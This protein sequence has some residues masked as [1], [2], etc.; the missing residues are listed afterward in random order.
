MLLLKLFVVP[1]GQQ[2]IND[3]LTGKEWG[4]VML[5]NQQTAVK[6]SWA[7]LVSS[8]QFWGIFLFFIL[9]ILSS[10]IFHTFYSGVWWKNGVSN[11]E[12]DVFRYAYIAG[13]SMS[14]IPAWI[15]SR[16]N[17]IYPLYLFCGLF[18]LALLLFYLDMNGFSTQRGSPN[19]SI[20]S[21]V[22]RFLIEFSSGAVLLLIPAMFASAVK[23]M[24]VF[25]L[26]FGVLVTLKSLYA[27]AFSTAMIYISK[28]SG[29]YLYD[30]PVFKINIFLAY[31]AAF[32]IIAMAFLLPVRKC[33]FNE[34][35]KQRLVTP[36]AAEY[37]PPMTVFFL[38]FIPFYFIFWFAKM[39]R[40]IRSYTQSSTLLT[41]N[42]AGWA[43]AFMPFATPIM[44][45]IISDNT[46]TI[47]EDKGQASGCK[48]GVIILF[49]FLI[50]P[51]AAALVQSKMNQLALFCYQRN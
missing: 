27:T 40:E 49:A 45:S 39:H 12:L 35:P 24:E 22:A 3:S 30:F 10:E 23:S 25:I 11:E 20:L 28:Y 19:L 36:A 51:L 16:I 37:R 2:N 15:A 14:I 31:L 9:M 46:K 41:P 18:L 21:V 43:A 6:W 29:V 13:L 7:D 38:F 33:L 50:P 4:G 8:Y 5:Q 32:I 17:K 48:T 34:T 26:S 1:D 44:L 42:G 47:L